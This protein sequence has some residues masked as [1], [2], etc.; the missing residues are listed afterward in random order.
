MA[1]DLDTFLSALSTTVDDLDRARLAT[2]H[3]SPWFL[4]MGIL[5]WRRA[6]RR[7]R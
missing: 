6:G 4:A 1:L 2:A 7:E 5:V 3:S